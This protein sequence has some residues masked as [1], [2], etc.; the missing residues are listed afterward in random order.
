[1][2][3]TIRQFE[4][5][6]L[7]VLQDEVSR[8]ERWIREASPIELLENI[9]FDLENALR[10]AKDKEDFDAT[11]IE[12]TIARLKNEARIKED[13]RV[14]EAPTKRITKVEGGPEKKDGE[15]DF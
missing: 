15:K 14:A 5:S 7:E 12:G 3:E 1:M 4:Q 6:P 2:G 9:I 8:L 13:A 10:K 11:E